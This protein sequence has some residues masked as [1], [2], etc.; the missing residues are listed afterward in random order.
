MEF[1]NTNL[2][3]L[4]ANATTD[5][6][7]TNLAAFKATGSEGEVIATDS[8]GSVV[9]S[10]TTKFMIALK[11]ADGTLDTTEIMD[12]SNVKS[13]SA[14]A[15]A[16]ATNKVTVVGYN[17]STGSI[18]VINDNLYQ[19]NLELLNYGSL[20]PE[21]R[22]LRQAHYQSPSSGT[23]ESLVAD[24][25]AGSLIRNFSR[26]Q[27]ARVKVERL[28]S[29]AGTALATGLDNVTFTKGSKYFTATDIDNAATNAAL[30]VGD[31]IRIGTA[32]SDP[33]YKITAID[34]TNNVGTLDVPFQGDTV[35]I[36]DTGLERVPV[37]NQAAASFGV[38]ITGVD[39]P[40]VVGKIRFEPIDWRPIT[41]VDCGDTT[42]T[43]VSAATK[44]NGD[45][46]RVAELE[47]F[48]QGNF[49]ERYRMGEPHLYDYRSELEAEPSKNYSV[50]V[51]DYYGAQKAGMNLVDT[52]SP[53]T[54]MVFS[55]STAAMNGLI[56]D[57]NKSSLF[58]ISTL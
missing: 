8:K 22:Y 25:L 26:E 41:L 17:G 45:G 23:T 7:E 38:K 33:V 57:L 40:F 51:I 12:L 32:V 20:S 34:S 55:A 15:Y 10:G 53:R 54:V 13:I 19:I 58:S 11:K 5:A 30:A 29:F 48:A 52:S 28:S 36:A 21:N 56:T 4:V 50:L 9:T 44:G 49:A 1:Q 14:K 39:Q 35:T 2:K 6:S 37:A 46:R 18:D 43:E 47:W 24:G 27:I 31:Y 16:A 3:V 42:V